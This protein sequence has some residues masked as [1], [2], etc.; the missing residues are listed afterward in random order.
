MDETVSDRLLDQRLRNRMMEE[1]LGL[2]DWED[3]I[4]WGADEYFNSFFDSFPDA[5]P[6]PSNSALT[7]AERSA[8]TD[9]L[10]LMNRAAN[11]TARHLTEDELIESG[12][13]ER[14]KPVAAKALAMMVAR[15]RFSDEVE[16]E[17][18]SAS[19]PWPNGS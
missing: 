16:E 11:A 17:L 13:P 18:P 4:G 6:L 15:G 14:I 7:A 12:W 5:P 3:F 19:P 9:V 1:L 10:E 8:L 2:V